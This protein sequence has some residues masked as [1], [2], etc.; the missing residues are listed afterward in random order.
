MNT[1]P[2][3]RWHAHIRET[4]PDVNPFVRALLAVVMSAQELEADS[5]LF[6][7]DALDE[8]AQAQRVT[9]QPELARQLTALADL[10][11]KRR[12]SRVVNVQDDFL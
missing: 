9:N 5:L 1:P 10:P 12:P 2:I 4:A 8:E 11:R 3:Q 6:V 7:A